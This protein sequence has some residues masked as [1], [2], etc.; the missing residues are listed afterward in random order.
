MKT[1]LEMKNHYFTI[2]I[3]SHEGCIRSFHLVFFNPKRISIL[4][5]N[6]III[7]LA[8]VNRHHLTGTL[9]GI[10]LI[11]LIYFSANDYSFMIIYRLIYSLYCVNTF[12][13]FSYKWLNNWNIIILPNTVISFRNLEYS[14]INTCNVRFIGAV[15]VLVQV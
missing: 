13:I 5:K 8:K 3:S 11:L 6:R 1:F 10:F 15:H 7:I 12:W 4:Y 9:L 2:V 14:P